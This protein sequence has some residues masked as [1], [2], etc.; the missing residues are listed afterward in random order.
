MQSNM[1]SIRGNRNLYKIMSTRVWT[2]WGQ[3]PTY[4]L[5]FLFSPILQWCSTHLNICWSSCCWNPCF[6]RSLSSREGQDTY[7]DNYNKIE[8]DTYIREIESVWWN[9]SWKILFLTV[10]ELGKASLKGWH[11][12]MALKRQWGIKKKKMVKMSIGKAGWKDI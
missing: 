5:I 9:L 7:S 12:E 1:I 6:Q 8:C 10:E 11:F 2:P 4:Y 3:W